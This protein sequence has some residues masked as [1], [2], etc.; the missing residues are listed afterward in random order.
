MKRKRTTLWRR[1]RE[2]RLRKDGG[3]RVVEKKRKETRESKE[4]RRKWRMRENGTRKG[5]GFVLEGEDAREVDSIRKPGTILYFSRYP[6]LFDP[7]R[8]LR[9]PPAS[10][11][12][13]RRESCLDTDSYLGKSAYYLG[14]RGRYLK[15]R[16]RVVETREEA[17]VTRSTTPSTVNVTINVDAAP[18][19]LEGSD[20]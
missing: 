5:R 7:A 19:Y 12:Q 8:S 10:Y 11:V 14:K 15:K 17:S 4:G 13:I 20:T 16:S 2:V 6:L 1:R 3:L 9:V 18:M